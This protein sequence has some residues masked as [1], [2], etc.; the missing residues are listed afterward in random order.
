MTRAATLLL[1][2][3]LLIA[4]AAGGRALAAERILRFVSD[5]TVERNGDLAVAET[6]RVEAE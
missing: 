5:V 2:V 3:A 1:A 4:G 6:I